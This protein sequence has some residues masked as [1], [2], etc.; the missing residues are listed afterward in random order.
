[1]RRAKRENDMSETVQFEWT[2]TIM[3][4]DI[5]IMESD[6][7]V[8]ASVH[9]DGEVFIDNIE[10]I[11]GRVEKYAAGRNWPFLDHTDPRISGLAELAKEILEADDDFIAKARDD[12]GL[13]YVGLGGNDPDGHFKLNSMARGA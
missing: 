4:G 13:V 10:L 12:A 1:M 3:E 8:T 7:L 5:L 2:A 11:N 6:V 9:D